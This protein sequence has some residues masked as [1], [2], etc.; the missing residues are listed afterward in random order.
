MHENKHKPYWHEKYKSGAIVW[1]FVQK[2]RLK[3]IN[4]LVIYMY[5]SNQFTNGLE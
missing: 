2:K 5:K 1:E 3:L 4:R